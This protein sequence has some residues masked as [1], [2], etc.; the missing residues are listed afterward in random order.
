[1]S[2]RS[3]R[4]VFRFRGCYPRPLDLF[5]PKPYIARKHAQKCDSP[6]RKEVT[7]VGTEQFLALD[8]MAPVRPRGQSGMMISDL[9]PHLASVA[10]D[11]CLLRGMNADNP[12]HAGAT[13]QCHTGPLVEVC[14]SMGAL[15]R[16]GRGPKKATL[17]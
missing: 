15:A 2:P 14:P 5:D 8:A 4:V 6:L 11:L 9:M 1:M 10:D 13:L 7:Q 12:Q 17:S 3:N 16:Y